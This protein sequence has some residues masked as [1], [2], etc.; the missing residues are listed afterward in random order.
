MKSSTNK[1]IRA[2]GLAYSREIDAAPV[3]SVKGMHLAAEEIVRL[4]KLYG[5][6]IVSRS[7]LARSLFELEEDEEIPE[8][9]YE[10]VARVLYEV[11]QWNS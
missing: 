7:A 3:L 5:V 11:E 6:P 9:L 4:A 1:P 2:V 8:E 10:V